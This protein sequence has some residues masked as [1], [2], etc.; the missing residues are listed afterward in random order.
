MNH[1]NHNHLREFSDLLGEQ[2][3]HLDF[4]ILLDKG[5][6]LNLNAFDISIEK[7]STSRTIS[8]SHADL[9]IR[10]HFQQAGA[11]WTVNFTLSSNTPIGLK[12]VKAL[13]FDYKCPRQ[14]PEH[15]LVPVL[16]D[17][18]YNTGFIRVS[19]LEYVTPDPNDSFSQSLKKIKAKGCG[20]FSAGHRGVFLSAVYPLNYNV[21]CTVSRL[22][23][24]SLRFMAETRYSANEKRK[25]YQSEIFYICTKK[26]MREAMEEY[27]ALYEPNETIFT[28]IPVGW[29]SWDYYFRTVSLDDVIENMEAIRKDP[30]LSDT[31]KYIVTD[32]GWSHN[33]GEWQPNYRFPGGLERLV[34]EIESRGFIP[35]IWTAPLQIE[36]LSYP[37]MRTPEILI[38]DQYGDPLP[39]DAGGHFLVDPTSPDGQAFLRDLF[40]RLYNI[41]FRLFKVDYV[42]S[43]LNVNRFY[44]E[45]TGPYEALRELFR[46]IRS[47]V[48]DSHIIGCSL[49]EECGPGIADSG[50][51][52]VDIHNHWS[53]VE[54]VT[55]SI[56]QN[57]W[58]HKKIWVNDPDFLIVRGQDTSIEKETNV[59]NPG[60]NNPNP[61]GLAKRWRYGPVFNEDE[62][63]TW[64]NIVIMSGGNV[65]LGDRIS[66]LNNK[67]LALIK[68]ALNPT[69]VAAQPLDLGDDLRPYFWLQDLGDTFRLLMV[70]WK[71]TV[72]ELSFDFLSYNLPA[73]KQ[74]ADYW[75]K[76]SYETVNGKLV[77]SLKPHESAL[78]QWKKDET[79]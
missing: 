72:Y 30:E 38:K 10:W 37:A 15:L 78:I 77:L 28:E 27:S 55:D 18:V 75:N 16:G 1:V 63:R 42:R 17:H 54:W 60:A 35:G 13:I 7:N 53:H 2:V 33:W 52:S 61:I 20:V 44:K 34:R 14:D 56:L 31:I 5:E 68:K 3:H 49:P 39:S 22:D 40:T 4:L 12:S 67:G 48:K 6:P 59:T 76:K 32:D 8:G 73:P 24:D 57:Y 11:G 29:N 41:G 50:R 23:H 45:D 62:A 58:L 25:V 21:N 36:A 65:F 51:I 47:C 9:Q 79:K 26:T 64:T 43:L 69:G 70:N 19:D 46:I 74:L 66:M 71:D